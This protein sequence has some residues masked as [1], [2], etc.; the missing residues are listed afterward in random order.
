MPYGVP[1]APAS[2]A[3]RILLLPK[4]IVAGERATL[5]V[6]DMSG[7]LTPGVIVSFSNG[8]RVTTDATGR[9]RFVAPLNPGSIFATLPGRPGHVSTRILSREEAAGSS[10]AIALTE[11]PRYAT[12][13]DRFEIDGHG[14]CGDASANE[15]KAGGEEVLVLAS[16]PVAM[17]LLPPAD[18]NP[19]P[20]ALSVA[21]SKNAAPPAMIH[22]VSLALEASTAPL[23]PNE[24]RT[25]RVNVRGTVAKLRLEARNLAPEVAALTGG[26]TVR[27]ASSGGTDNFA[28]F[29]V[30][31][32]SHGNFLISIRLLPSYVA[33]H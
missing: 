30:T 4:R 15:V 31:G 26:V 12:L 29:E 28:S 13:A 22:F 24:K 9:G 21:C 20:A 5:A 7:R 14:F 16:S 17:V 10:S 33:V 18:M 1:A 2:S 8:D 19:G 27:A 23:A 6:L 32:R 11:A 3:A 25:L